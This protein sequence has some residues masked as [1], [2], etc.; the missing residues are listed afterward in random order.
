M[1]VSFAF[2]IANQVVGKL[3]SLALQ[4]V[5]LAWGVQADLE[6]LKNTIS[7]IQAVISDAEEQ[8]SNNRQLSD[9]LRKL[10]NALYEAKDVL[11][12]FEYRGFTAESCKRWEHRK[13]GTQFPFNFKSTCISLQNGSQNEEPEREF[14]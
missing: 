8:Q 3:G 13:T 14:G 10:N 9:W 5:A 7:T 1:A 11:D 12:E 2:D 4:E 6:D